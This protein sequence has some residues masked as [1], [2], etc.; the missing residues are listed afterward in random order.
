MAINCL[1]MP[2]Q[3]QP[4]PQPQSWPLPQSRSH[5]VQCE[6]DGSVIINKKHLRSFT[7][8]L[9]YPLHFLDFETTSM[10]IPEFPVQRPYQQIPFQYSMHIKSSVNSEILHYE[11]L[12]ESEK[13][14]P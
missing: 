3:P 10:A 1:W 13:T 11:F 14:E 7:D 9:E 2:T 5:Q 6:R 8:Q 4:R 12:A